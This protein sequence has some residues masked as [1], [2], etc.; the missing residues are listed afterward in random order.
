MNTYRVFFRQR[1][2]TYY[3]VAGRNAQEAVRNAKVVARKFDRVIRPVVTRIQR[4]YR[5]FE[6]DLKVRHWTRKRS[7]A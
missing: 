6:K 4:I 1:P 2:A 5:G 3:S 7:W